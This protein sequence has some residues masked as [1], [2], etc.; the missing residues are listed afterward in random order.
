MGRSVLAAGTL[1][2]ATLNAIAQES[3][4]LGQ[5]ERRVHRE[6]EQSLP[7][8]LLIP[9]GFRAQTAWPLIVWLHGSGEKGADNVSQ[10]WPIEMT[11][12]A[13]PEKCPAFVMVPQCPSNSSW[14][15]IGFNKP[16][17]MPE[18]ARMVVATV[19]ELQKEFGLDDR[20]LYIGG[21][22]MGGC[23]T[24]DILS[25]CPQL[26][27]AAFPIAGPPGDREV[28]APVI[29]HMPIWAFHGDSDRTAPVEGTRSIVA[30]L[31]AA[32]AEVK[33]TEYRGGGHECAETLANPALPEWLLAQKRPAKQSRPGPC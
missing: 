21:F 22:S 18:P 28:L 14:L 23:A 16:V 5:F 31:K 7:Y 24:W 30:A 9:K 20:R 11:F 25:R 29:K 13:D 1:L 12:L 8:R 15:A 4:R 2:I 3:P 33:Y 26:F 27:A 10:I 32:G 6:G 17:E 19:A